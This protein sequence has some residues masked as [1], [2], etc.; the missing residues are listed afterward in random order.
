MKREIGMEKKANSR[1]ER[2]KEKIWNAY[3]Q[4]L[5]E[6]EE[7]EINVKQVCALAHVNRSTFYAYYFDLN[8]LLINKEEELNRK[9][10]QYLR[11][12][13][14]YGNIG[15]RDDLFTYLSLVRENVGA[16]YACFHRGNQGG[17]HGEIREIMRN[18]IAYYYPPTDGQTPAVHSLILDFYEEGLYC[19]I[20]N[21]VN[22]GCA[23][24]EETLVSVI[25]S[26]MT[27]FVS[28]KQN[29]Q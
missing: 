6:K 8:D 12:S 21:W 13:S 11:Q 4:L 28:S 16:F 9:I 7:N 29:P 1:S 22:G 18:T 20:R 5:Q 2:T 25:R 27:G 23:E 24:S 17:L 10:L 19:I 14:L 26:C 3:L 15:N